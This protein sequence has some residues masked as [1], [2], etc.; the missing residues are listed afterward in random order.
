MILEEL[1]TEFLNRSDEENMSTIIAI[2]ANRRISKKPVIVK[3]NNNSKSKTKQTTLNMDAITPE[4]AALLLQ[5][6]KG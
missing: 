3:N 1:I 4:M 6:L 5:K 2:R